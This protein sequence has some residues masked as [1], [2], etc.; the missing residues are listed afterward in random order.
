MSAILRS[1]HSQQ[2]GLNFECMTSIR[3]HCPVMHLGP[4][5]KFAVQEPNALIIQC[6]ISEKRRQAN[7]FGIRGGYDHA[8]ISRGN[9]RI[10]R[11]IREFS[12]YVLLWGSSRRNVALA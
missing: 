1:M 6:D 8:T 4:Q 10:C 9:C 7:E 3:S 2:N 5:S 11:H 12:N